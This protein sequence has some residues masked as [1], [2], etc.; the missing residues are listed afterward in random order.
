LLS[1]TTPPCHF[2]L[3]DFKLGFDEAEDRPLFQ[4]SEEVGIN[5][6]MEMKRYRQ[7]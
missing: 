5:F 4:K 3:V 6:S 2:A 7:G 1:F